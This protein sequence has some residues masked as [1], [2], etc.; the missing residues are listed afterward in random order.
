MI[1]EACLRISTV[2]GQ[3]G[4][5]CSGV[6]TKVYRLAITRYDKSLQYLCVIAPELKEDAKLTEEF[7][8]LNLNLAACWLSLVHMKKLEII[9]A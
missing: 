8:T 9:V 6:R 3:R 5:D 2:K 4:V 7:G 1:L